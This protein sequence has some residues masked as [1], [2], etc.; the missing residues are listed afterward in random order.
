[1]QAEI[2]EICGCTSVVVEQRKRLQ[3][4]DLLVVR[5]R[6]VQV[7]QDLHSTKHHV[8]AMPPP[9]NPNQEPHQNKTLLNDSPL[10][11]LMLDQCL[12]TQ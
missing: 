6:L 11:N 1:M 9:V 10:P 5:L 3:L 2:D 8:Q 7:D 4:E 12:P